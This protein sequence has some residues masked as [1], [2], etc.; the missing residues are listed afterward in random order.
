MHSSDRPHEYDAVLGGQA[1]PPLDAPVLGG[2]DRAKLLR[3]RL[4]EIYRSGQRN[5]AVRD[6]SGIDLSGTNLYQVNLSESNLSRSKLVASNLRKASLIRT[7]FYGADL[8]SANFTDAILFSANLRDANLRNASLFGSDLRVADLQNADLRD[9][10]L[11]GADLNNAL[12]LTVN[13]I[14]SA[15]NWQQAKYDAN[16]RRL[17]HLPPSL[18]FN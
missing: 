14:K 8:G 5:F 10:D 15:R 17:L 6:L 13:Q 1:L 9:A 16:W 2:L 12:N 3:H 18:K 7:N 4:L 11:F